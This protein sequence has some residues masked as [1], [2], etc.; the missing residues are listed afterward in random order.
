MNKKLKDMTLEEVRHYCAYAKDGNTVTHRK[1]EVFP[2]N[3]ALWYTRTEPDEYGETF[4][5]PCLF[6]PGVERGLLMYGFM[7]DPDQCGIDIVKEHASGLCRITP[8]SL[9]DYLNSQ[10][11]H[12]DFIGRNMIVFVHQFSPD[13]AHK[14]CEYRNEWDALRAAEEDAQNEGREAEMRAKE[15]AERAKHDA[16][17]ASSK[18]LYLGWADNMTPVRFGKVHSTMSKTIAHNGKVMTRRDFIVQK[19]DEG[20]I[21]EK[22]DNVV[23]TYGSGWNRKQSKPK[24]EYWLTWGSCG[25]T[26]TKTEYDFAMYLMDYKNVEEKNNEAD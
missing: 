14:Y 16:E 20:Y 12:G 26:I 21:P 17:I 22:Q 7:S 8:E 9:I 2:I 13:D 4:C 3:G 5:H 24:T 6:F 11:A 23:T 1:M 25:Y 19:V 10:M 18:A 15:K